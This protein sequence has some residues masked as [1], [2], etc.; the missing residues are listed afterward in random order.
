MMMKPQSMYSCRL[1]PG[2]RSP[3]GLKR[4]GMPRPS[5]RDWKQ[6]RR[7][8]GRRGE[9]AELQKLATTAPQS[10]GVW[11]GL[12]SANSRSSVQVS[13]YY[14]TFKSV[15]GRRRIICSGGARGIREFSEVDELGFEGAGY[16]YGRHLRAMGGGTYVSASGAS[17]AASTVHQTHNAAARFDIP[18]DVLP[19]QPEEELDRMLEAINLNPATLPRDLREALEALEEADED[20]EG[21]EDGAEAGGVSAPPASAAVAPPERA[22]VS[23]SEA[24]LEELDDAFVMQAAGALRVCYGGALPCRSR[25][26]SPAPHRRRGARAGVGRRGGDARRQRRL[27]HRHG[28]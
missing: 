24:G 19:S 1:R 11:H 10:R 17:L 21:E 18:D 2:F 7:E 20:D 16:D 5:Y 15:P 12:S 4:V 22:H 6:P 26:P 23:L 27:R 28:V 14:Q 9:V 8:L 13:E 3:K 25:T